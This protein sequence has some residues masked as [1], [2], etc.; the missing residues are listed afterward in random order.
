MLRRSRRSSID[1]LDALCLRGTTT[2]NSTASRLLAHP[3]ERFQLQMYD[4]LRQL[5]EEPPDRVRTCLLEHQLRAVGGLAY[6]GEPEVPRSAPSGS[7]SRAWRLRSAGEALCARDG[8]RFVSGDALALPVRSTGA[9]Y[10]VIDVGGGSNR[11]GEAACCSASRA[12][13][14]S[15]GA[16]LYGIAHQRE[17][18]PKIANPSRGRVSTA[19]RARSRSTSGAPAEEGYAATSLAACR[20]TGPFPGRSAPCLRPA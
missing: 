6:L 12:R 10:V 15:G 20:T 11:F 5:L 16:F 8:W 14:V 18:L 19:S 3:P 17:G 9:F 7:T 1:L 2:N 4:E 13:A